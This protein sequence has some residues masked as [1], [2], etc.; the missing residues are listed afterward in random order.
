MPVLLLL[1]TSFLAVSSQT[2][3]AVQVEEMK[4]LDFLTGEWKGKG[5][6][7]NLDGS[8]RNEFTQKAKVQAKA[9]G[10]SLRITDE[11][12]Y[13]TIYQG[14]SPIYSSSTL[15]ATIYYDEGVK[16]YRW[17]GENSYGRKNPLEAKLIEARTLQYGM[18]FTVMALPSNGYRKT[19]IKVTE[20]GE[21]HE[22]IEVWYRDDWFKAEE[23]ILKK[24][25]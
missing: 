3:S 2:P 22:T 4:K 10:A 1:L 15:D 20:D 12:K 16:I 9:G 13:K 7:F 21:W 14:G 5:Q 23:S 18:P 24:V 8:P 19:T 25:K 11:R 17:R 6:E